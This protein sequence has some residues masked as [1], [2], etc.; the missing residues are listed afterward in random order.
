MAFF[1]VSIF[2]FLRLIFRRKTNVYPSFFPLLS[3]ASLLVRMTD[4][5]NV[6][7][8]AFP[9]SFGRTYRS[10]KRE[11]ERNQAGRFDARRRFQ[12]MR[13]KTRSVF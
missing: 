10:A 9:H 8:D 5:K 3:E 2:L 6:T 4:L 1:L 11:E 7:Y 12:G 13:G